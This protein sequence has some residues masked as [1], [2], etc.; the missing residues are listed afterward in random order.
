SEALD[1]VVG[2]EL[3]IASPAD[4]LALFEAGPHQRESPV[5]G[6]ARR[7]SCDARALRDRSLG[8]SSKRN[9]WCT[10]ITPPRRSSPW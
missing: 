1:L 9:A 4:L 7:S 6:E 3:A 2:E 5:V 10:S 8:S